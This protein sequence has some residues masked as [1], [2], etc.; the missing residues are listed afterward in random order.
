M[1][2]GIAHAMSLWAQRRE[3]CTTDT[4]RRMG[5]LR[6]LAIARLQRGRHLLN[7]RTFC[8]LATSMIEPSVKLIR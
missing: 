2:A 5:G 1:F 8:P 6:L 4:R 3:L 7:Q